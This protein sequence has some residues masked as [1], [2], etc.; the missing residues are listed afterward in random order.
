[1]Q[2][3]KDALTL[4]NTSTHQRY[5]INTST[6]QKVRPVAGSRRSELAHC[7][8]KSCG[9]PLLGWLAPAQ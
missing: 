4:L 7:C 8:R 2:A 1:M 6:A 5:R 3:K 9:A